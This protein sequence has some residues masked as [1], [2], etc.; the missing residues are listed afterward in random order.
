MFGD[1]YR[2][3]SEQVDETTSTL[4]DLLK[5]SED[6]RDMKATPPLELSP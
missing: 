4:Q 3:S 5:T 1:C 6:S 2:T